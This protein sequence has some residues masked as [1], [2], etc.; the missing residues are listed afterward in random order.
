[1]TKE[2]PKTNR[3]KQFGHWLQYLV[4]ACLM[5]V[6]RHLPFTFT[7]ACWRRFALLVCRLAPKLTRTVRNNI[8]TTIGQNWDHDRIERT[9]RETF[10]NSGYFIAEFMHQRNFT[11]SILERVE[12]LD[13]ETLDRIRRNGGSIVLTSGHL[14]NW[15]ILGPLFEALGMRVHVLYKPMSNRFIDRY[16]KKYRAATAFPVSTR[17]W[18][19]KCPVVM[20]EG[21]VLGVISDQD[22]GNHGIFVEFLGR[23]AATFVGPAYFSV[24]FNAPVVFTATQRTAPGHFRVTIEEIP[25]DESITDPRAQIDHLTHAWVKRLDRLVRETPAQ[26][27]WFHKRWKTRPKN[28]TPHN[29]P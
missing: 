23:P 19:E 8:A 28:D 29:E 15:E 12:I 11:A 5:T 27:F 17:E 6:F 2:K 3:M 13:R 26:Y 16:I 20:N 14:C 9:V 25:R 7:C 10:I 22:A 1:M 4:V 21:G 24:H 18:R